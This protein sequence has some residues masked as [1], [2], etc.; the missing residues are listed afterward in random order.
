[1]GLTKYILENSKKIVI[2]ITPPFFLNICG[3]SFFSLSLKITKCK[4]PKFCESQGTGIHRLSYICLIHP[5]V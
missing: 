5:S 3:L 4:I 1:M 2:P